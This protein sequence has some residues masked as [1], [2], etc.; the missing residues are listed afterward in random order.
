MNRLE[1]TIGGKKKKN[2]PCAQ[3]EKERKDRETII[4][5]EN[6]YSRIKLES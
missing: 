2:F 3:F 1:Q 4:E 6:Y 5:K